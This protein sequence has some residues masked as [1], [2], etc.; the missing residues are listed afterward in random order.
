MG[1]LYVA[2]IP[3]MSPITRGSHH[4]IDYLLIGSTQYL[5]IQN[6]QRP[7]NKPKTNNFVEIVFYFLQEVDE[8]GTISF[9]LFALQTSAYAGEDTKM[10]SLYPVPLK[11]AN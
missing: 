1:D 3:K 5:V 9:V 8:K 10:F 4:E 2:P 11:V 7:C 6:R